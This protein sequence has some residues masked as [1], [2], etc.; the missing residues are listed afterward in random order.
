MRYWCEQLQ[1]VESSGKLRILK[2]VKKHFECEKYLLEIS[3]FKHRQAVTKLRIFSH[4]KNESSVVLHYV[5]WCFQIFEEFV[6]IFYKTKAS[7]YFNVKGRLQSLLR[8]GSAH[9]KC[10]PNCPNFAFLKTFLN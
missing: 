7:L 8:I 4:A 6:D 2:K 9:N 3:N 5:E 1:P 10:G